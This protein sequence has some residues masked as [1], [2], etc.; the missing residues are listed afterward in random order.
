MPLA[1]SAVSIFYLLPQIRLIVQRTQQIFISADRKYVRLL[2]RAVGIS[3]LAQI[4]AQICA[5]AGQKA[6][7]DKIEM[8]ARIMIAVYTLPLIGDMIGLITAFLGE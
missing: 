5:D 1:V 6:M 2:L 8:A 4:T 7:G 3:F